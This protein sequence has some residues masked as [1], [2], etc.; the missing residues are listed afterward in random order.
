MHS[1]YCI[2]FIF[3]LVYI[4]PLI[5]FLWICWYIWTDENKS[6]DLAFYYPFSVF[7][8][9]SVSK[10]SDCSAEDLGSIPG[11]GRSA[12][13]G[14]G[15]PLHYS[16]LVNPMD[17]GAW[18]TTVHEVA[19]VGHDWVTKPPPPVSSIHTAIKSRTRFVVKIYFRMVI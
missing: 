17:R 6:R 2:V 18:R 12:G 1:S 10:E 7:L 15:N 4:I 13:E 5:I 14:S 11:S 9:G 19:R 16:C 8:H 3:L